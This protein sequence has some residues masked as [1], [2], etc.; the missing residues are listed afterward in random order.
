MG[1][2]PICVLIGTLEIAGPNEH[3]DSPDQSPGQWYRMA[4][5]CGLLDALA[6]AFHGLSRKALQP[7]GPCQGDTGVIV[8]FEVEI[9]RAGPLIARSTLQRCL[10]LHAGAAKVPD[11]VE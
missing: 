3:G 5:R 6:Y 2:Q 8:V 10:K 4:H 1:D 11:M 7:Q 9:D